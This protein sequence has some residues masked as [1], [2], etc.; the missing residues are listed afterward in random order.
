M[1]PSTLR[2]P[3]APVV[4]PAGEPA[5]PAVGVGSPSEPRRNGAA[6]GTV[7]GTMRRFLLLDG[8]P[9]LGLAAAAQLELWLGGGPD[10]PFHAVVALAFTLPLVARRR[11][12]LGVL[13]VV[14]LGLTALSAR[15]SDFFTF[16]QL[17][18]M[19]VAAYSVA[20][21]AGTPKAVA[22]LVLVNAAGA[23][24]S[25]SAGTTAPGDFLW[26]ALLL[27][28]P[29]LAGRALGAWRDR[30][31]E[32]ERLTREVGRLAAA[33]ERARIA[34]ELH[35]AVAH[36]VN[37]A[38]IHAEAAEELLDRD[39]ERVREPL[40]R[41]QQ[42]GREALVELRRALGALRQPDNAPTSSP[43]GLAE[44]P[45]LVEPVRAAGL[46]VALRVDGRQRRLSPGLDLSAYRIVQEAL[47][48]TLKHAGAAHVDVVVRYG[49]HALE[50]EIA[51]DGAAGRPR[52]AN[53]G[54]HGL[55]SMRERALLFGGE[56]DAAPRR[57][58]GFRVRARLPF[59]EGGP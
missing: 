54:G 38:V 36:C 31:A 8:A 12:P 50:L 24:N 53:G 11:A 34:R 19:L 32:L 27:S 43:P 44:L 25:L 23:G 48:N 20:A 55:V 10:R 4:P 40:H 26:P 29:W 59:G 18:A 9:A 17:L 21:Y 49:E 1:M 5:P 47:T 2:R 52:R 13:V 3:D 16:A 42:S 22:G 39:P 28:G 7:A 35:D 15:G 46:D 37:V 14:C 6:T 30:A 41:I 51:D 58:G 45:A 33:E 56:L 57:G